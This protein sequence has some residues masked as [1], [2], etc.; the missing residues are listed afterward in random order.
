MVPD[1]CNRPDLMKDCWM[2]ASARPPFFQAFAMDVSFYYSN[3]SNVCRW[4]ARSPISM[5]VL[6]VAGIGLCLASSKSATQNWTVCN[7]T[8]V[9]DKS[10]EYIIPPNHGWWACKTGLTPCIFTTMFMNV[11]DVCVLVQLIPKFTLYPNDDFLELW[12]PP[13]GL[14]RYKREP[15]AA[16]TLAVVLGLSGIGAGTGIS[17]LALQDQKFDELSRIM[18]ANV[19]EMQQQIEDITDSLASLAE[20]VLQNRRGLDLLLLQQG[21]LCAAL[22]EECCVYVDKTGLVRESI[23]RVREGLELRKREREKAESWYE[24]WFSTSPWVTTLLPSILGPLFGL[25]LLI[26][27]GP[28]AFSRLTTFIKQQIENVTRPVMVHYHAISQYDEEGPS[29]DGLIR[30]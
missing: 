10:H 23:K 27:F 19:K 4:N 17:S 9:P 5:I 6:E 1:E 24:N 8:L 12:T 28:W 30:A 29:V 14:S 11:S 13:I 21:G 2:C 25:L 20:V 18:D 26:S 22:K 16:L 3:N 15:F 7:D